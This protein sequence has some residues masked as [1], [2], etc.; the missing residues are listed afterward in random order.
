[1]PAYLTAEGG[2]VPLI[3]VS[4]K[5]DRIDEGLLYKAQDGSYWLSCVCVFETDAKGR[6]IVAQ[7]IPKERYAA[8]EKGPPVGYWRE[9]GGKEPP[10]R[11]GGGFNL[12]RYKATATAHK[13]ASGAAKYH[14]GQEGFFPSPQAA[15]DTALETQREPQRDTRH[16]SPLEEPGF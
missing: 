15:F 2:H 12:A 4:I 9:I 14:D 3:A 7:S 8:G 16:G 10:A 5:L 13:P 6:T 1:M 11:E